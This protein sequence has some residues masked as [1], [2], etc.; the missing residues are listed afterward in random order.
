MD[1][2][3]DDVLIGDSGSVISQPN[4]LATPRSLVYREKI[5]NELTPPIDGNRL[6]WS[7]ILVLLKYLPELILERYQFV[8]STLDE[9]EYIN[10]KKWEYKTLSEWLDAIVPGDKPLNP[11]LLF[12]NKV[13][14]KLKAEESRATL[15]L[16]IE[17]FQRRG[18][19]FK[20]YH[21]TP[22]KFF[23][24]LKADIL[25]RAIQA[26]GLLTGSPLLFNKQ[27]CEGFN[28][29]LD[30]L[31]SLIEKIPDTHVPVESASCR[32]LEF[33]IGWAA[34]TAADDTKFRYSKV[35]REFQATSSKEL[36]DTRRTGKLG[37]LENGYFLPT[38]RNR[39]RRTRKKQDL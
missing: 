18:D 8:S 3:T 26:S 16:L 28:S 6:H 13:Q 17:M 35:F 39:P 30:S 2:F 33:V 5:R 4:F 10:E 19:I 32:P 1:I 11:D 27:E 24:A 9:K 34:I 14:L 23:L 22:A 20:K 15:N 25:E 12:T 31:I 29:N 7:N 38:G 21:D 37:F 36:R